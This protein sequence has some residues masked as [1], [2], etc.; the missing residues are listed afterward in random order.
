M[1][2]IR[3]IFINKVPLGHESSNLHSSYLSGKLSIEVCEEL[4]S[5]WV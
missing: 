4:W 1:Q 3:K 5:Q 2:Q